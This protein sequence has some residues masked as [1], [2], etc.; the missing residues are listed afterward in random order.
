[1]TVHLTGWRRA[2][3]CIYPWNDPEVAHVQEL[4]RSKQL[5]PTQARGLG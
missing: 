1:M 4:V 3:L 5:T 2:G